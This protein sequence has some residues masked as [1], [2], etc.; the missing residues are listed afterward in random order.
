MYGIIPEI[1]ET[2]SYYYY[3]YYYLLLLRF[4]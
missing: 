3:Y 1:F 4:T 2:V